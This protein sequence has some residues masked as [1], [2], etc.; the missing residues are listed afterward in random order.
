MIDLDDF[1]EAIERLG[2][3]SSTVRRNSA[4]IN[5]AY[6]PVAEVSPDCLPQ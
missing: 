5:A 2:A 3:F 6:P 1:A 4:S